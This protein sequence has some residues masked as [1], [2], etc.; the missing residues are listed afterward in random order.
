MQ[1][2]AGGQRGE[3][4]E[5]TETNDYFTILPGADEKG[6][7]KIAQHHRVSNRISAPVSPT[8]NRVL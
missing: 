8:K 7:F 4:L 1:S 5:V 6:N 3:G 2:R